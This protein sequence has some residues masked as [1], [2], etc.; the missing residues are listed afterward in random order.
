MLKSVLQ[1]Q[2]VGRARRSLRIQ[3]LTTQTQLK[4]LLCSHIYI[5]VLHTEGVKLTTMQI[6]VKSMVNRIQRMP[7][8]LRH[9]CPCR[10]LQKGIPV[11][12]QRATTSLLCSHMQ[13]FLYANNLQAPI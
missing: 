11:H 3:I 9:C 7:K 8:L 4:I 5:H 1:L 12:H 10:M 13:W 2:E 6:R